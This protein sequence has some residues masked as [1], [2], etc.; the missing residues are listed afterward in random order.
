VRTHTQNTVAECLISDSDNYSN[1]T[2][3]ND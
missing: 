3:N 1:K 2:E